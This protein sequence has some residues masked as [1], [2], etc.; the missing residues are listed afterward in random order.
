MQKKETL[1]SKDRKQ[2]A[3]KRKTTAKE[4]QKFHKEQERR[5][6]KSSANPKKRSSSKIE[7]AVNSGKTIKFENISRE[8]KFRRESDKKIRN[9]K[10]HDFEDGYYIDEY[11]EK[12]R[13]ERR[14]KEIQKQESEVIHKIKKPLT[15]K[16]IKIRRI[17]ISTSI[18]LSVLLIGAILS[19]TVLFKTENIEI[20]GCEEYYYDEQIIAFSNV[21]LQ[22]N[23]FV[24]AM[25]S[26]PENISQNL[27]YVEE[28]KVGFSIPDTVTI[29]LTQAIP[30][31]VI[32]NGN[33]YLIISSKGRILDVATE[34]TDNL[35]ELT[36]GELNSTEIGQYVSFSDENIPDILE[37]VSESLRANEV[38]NITGFDVT[39][40]ANITLN[41]DNRITINIGLPEDVDYKIRTAMTIINEKLDPNNTGT[42]AGTLDVS[43]CNTNKMSHYKPAETTVV[44]TTVPSTTA[45]VTNYGAGAGDY[46]WQDNSGE[47]AYSGYSYDDGTGDTWTDDSYT[48]DSYYGE[49]TDDANADSVYSDGTDGVVTYE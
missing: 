32:K 1:S 3:K 11:S 35:P 10:P 21:K 49:G 45:P 23:I 24:A 34:N 16:Q 2:L 40:P 19:L 33:N 42:I 4:A 18:F 44:T 37:D 7:Q 28:A 20:E 26:T 17:T 36:C 29:K 31:Y 14:A 39:D 6:K 8:E 5:A 12:K 41:Y 13:Q 47:D 15:S 48:N 38:K 22:Q 27:P 9:L 43:T 30:S 46:T 25:S